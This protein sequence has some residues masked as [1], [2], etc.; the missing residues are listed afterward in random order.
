MPDID[1]LLARTLVI[2]AHP[3]D[4]AA[5]CG[6]LLQRMR[7]PVV[8][9]ATDGAPEDPYFWARYGSREAYGEMRREEAAD[10]GQEAAKLLDHDHASAATTHFG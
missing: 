1:V 6:V 4:E 9:F 10:H 3:D 8:L 7:E 5:G 2:V